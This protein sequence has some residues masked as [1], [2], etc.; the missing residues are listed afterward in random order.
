VDTVSKVLLGIVALSALVQA[1][2]LVALAW[3][4]WRLFQQVGELKARLGEPVASDVQRFARN[5]A[6]LSATLKEQGHRVESAV[7]ATTAS[8]QDT[9]DYVGRAV[10]T[11]VRPLVELG[12]LWQAVKR[13]IGVYRSLRP[14]SLRVTVARGP[15]ARHMA[16][17]HEE[18][19]ERQT[20]GLTEH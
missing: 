10:R 14:T 3:A 19:D 16:G 5:V 7:G 1:S 9:A 11:G 2:V 8:L 17:P 15:S 20:S 13:G 18:W 12:A 4:G 6:D